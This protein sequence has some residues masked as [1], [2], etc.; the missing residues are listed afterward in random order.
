MVLVVV[1]LSDGRV[2]EMPH[3]HYIIRY[4][5]TVVR[6]NGAEIKQSFMT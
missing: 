4:R 6:G 3:I 1:S 2:S 5:W